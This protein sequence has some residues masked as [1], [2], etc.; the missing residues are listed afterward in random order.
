MK[1]FLLILLMCLAGCLARQHKPE[2]SQVVALVN[3]R[4]VLEET[5]RFR[6]NLES[7]LYEGENVK[8]RFQ[9][10]KHR[11][12]DQI[13]QN[14]VITDWGLHQGIVLT[15]EEITKGLERLKSGYTEKAF[16]DYL[17]EKKVPY[18]HWRD[19][20]YEKLL[21]KKVLDEGIFKNVG[22]TGPKDIQSYYQKNAEEF[23]TPERVRVRHIVTDTEEKAKKLYARVLGG[24][25]F[26]KVAVMNSQSPD[27]SKG[28]DL[29]YFAR[30]TYPK[31][32]DDACFALK[33]GE[34]SPIIRSPYGFHIFKSID[35]KPAGMLSLDEVTPRIY[36]I[37]IKQTSEEVFDKWYEEAKKASQ[38]QIIEKVLAKIKPPVGLEK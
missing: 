34:I 17:A 14:R 38:I 16:E 32:F 22:K 31:E 7:H 26:A 25:N 9:S 4:S 1:N 23:K 24:E 5:L 19:M 2:G 21:V 3:G 11:I 33:A 18:E 36:S 35:T 6:L 28:G 29:G 27:R 13:I 15:D 37:L 12:L 20:A 8:E 10:L 30:G